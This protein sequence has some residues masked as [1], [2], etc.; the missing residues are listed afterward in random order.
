MHI[1]ET[2]LE[3]QREP[4]ARPFAFKGSAFHEKWNLVVRL[5]DADGYEAFG[6]GG[7]AVLWSDAAVFAAHTEMGGNLL[8]A[9]LLE[10]ALQH[11]KGKE[12][13]D[14]LALFDTIENDV[15]SYA[16]AITGQGDLRRT[17]ALIALVALDNAAWTLYAK[18]KKLA[19]FDALIPEKFRS[20]LSHRQS[21]VALVPAVSY[22]LPIDELR[23]ILDSGA[24]IL[25][26]KIGHPGDEA[27]MLKTDM[28]CLSQIHSLARRYETEMTDSGQVLYYLDAN[29]RYGEKNSMARLLDHAD[30]EGMLDRIV[31]IEE[32][33]SRP[34]DI[35]VHGLPA[36]FAGDESIETV[37]DV[38][39][40]LEQG[41]GAMAIK[42]AGKTLSLAFRMI[43]AAKNS[44]PCFVAD[45][46]CVPV[47]VEW[48]KNVAARLPAFPG[49]KGGLME[50]N[51]PENYRTWDRMLSEYALPNASWLR[52]RGGAF[53]L[54]K[55]YYE[56][57]GGI[58]EEPAVYTRLF[59][60]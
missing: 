50:S 5:K 20:F 42:P 55:N 15:F 53:V 16:K 34:A 27:E 59:K 31:L 48:N 41:Y 45:N 54:D 17:F 56:Q 39:T 30:N 40:R 9:S 60:K 47:L 38:H 36:R 37:V 6:I 24:Y 19:T 32:P 11:I 23:A 12:F 10:F 25:K 29:G 33:F 8:Q 1:V 35:D 49:V 46:A 22:T 57:S 3:I 52:P 28:A 13:S 21:H 2:D 26:I 14:P 51:G 58:F 43:E 18:Q 4:F 7:L 44:V